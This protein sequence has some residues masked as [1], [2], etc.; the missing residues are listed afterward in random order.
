MKE[1]PKQAFV[2]ELDQRYGPIRKVGSG[3][4]LFESAANIL[5]YVRY[6][7]LHGNA[8][9]FGLDRRTL[10]SLKKGTGYVCFVLPPRQYFILPV[11]A[12]ATALK[13]V[14]AAYDEN[15]KVQ[16]IQDR[17]ATWLRVA[18]KGRIPITDFQ[19][20]YP[21]AVAGSDRSAELV[22]AER[23]FTHSEIQRMMVRLGLLLGH[24]VWVP[25]RDA[26]RLGGSERVGDG[27]L[28]TLDIVAPKRTLPSIESVD[29]IWL[30]KG[31][32]SPIALFEIEHST[33]IYSGLLRLNDILI[34]YDAPRLGIVSYEKRR[35]LFEREVARRT[36]ESSGLRERCRFYNYKTIQALLARLQSSSQEARAIAAELFGPDAKEGRR[37]R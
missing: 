10:H 20:E 9:F 19:D 31:S 17:D 1:G 33:T 28:P 25:R 37:V 30:R 14:S 22:E 6:S 13:G 18:G 2:A 11:A 3:N 4:S 32:Y 29:V 15:F 36:F 34:D 23:K 27:C 21:P 8:G 24:D 12:V 26:N 35:G 5:F 7:K 16:I